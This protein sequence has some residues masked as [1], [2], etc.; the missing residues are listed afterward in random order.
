M[1]Q[2]KEAPLCARKKVGLEVGTEKLT[3]CLCLITIMQDNHNLMKASLRNVAK[4]KYLGM[5]VTN[6]NCF[7]E[8]IK[9]RLYLGNAYDHSL[10][11]HFPISFL[12]HGCK[13]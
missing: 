12:L 2:N 4:L 1:K 8:E 7:N 9:S 11:N 3:I 6:Q 13:T 10:Q 5:T